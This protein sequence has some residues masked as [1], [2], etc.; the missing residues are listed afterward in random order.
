MKRRDA[1]KVLGLGAAM[2]VLPGFG[3]AKPAVMP[4]ALVFDTFGTV[5]DWAG[6]DH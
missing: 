6:L 1:L 5:V 3:T 2:E 4:K